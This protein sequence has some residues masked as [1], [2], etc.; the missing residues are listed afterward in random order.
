MVETVDTYC[1][2]PQAQLF[3]AQQLADSWRQPL[4]GPAL[5]N[6]MDEA[7]FGPLA[8]TQLVYIESGVG[9]RSQIAAS[10]PDTEIFKAT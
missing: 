5:W 10:H 7:I 1:E 6:E 9:E 3:G 8:G 4:N 2:L